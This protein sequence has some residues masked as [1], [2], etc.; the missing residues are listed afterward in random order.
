M[1]S[2]KTF[3]QGV[4]LVKINNI[5]YNHCHDADFF[6]ERPEGSGDYLLLLLK[7]DAIF[8]IDGRDIIVPKDSVFIYPKGRP[9]YYR[10]LPQHTFENDWLHFDFT[11]KD[12]ESDFIGKKIPFETPIP[13]NLNFLSYCIK[14]ISYEKNSNHP[15]REQ[16]IRSY[17]FLMFIKIAEQVEKAD[18]YR[19]GE[20][21]EMLATIRNKIYAEPYVPRG[22][23]WAAHEVRMSRSTFQHAYKKMFGV[24][25]VQDFIC[26]KISYSKM[27]LTSTN[28]TIEEVAKQS[29]Y[30]SYVHYARQFREQTGMSPSEYRKAQSEVK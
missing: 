1:H 7:T 30:R 14:S 13:M 19:S 21:Y 22:V 6:I 27:L 26:S 29:G 12:K 4:D 5:G 25:Y 15:Y 8:T 16:S 18:V 24:S 17:L 20:Q 23:N 9:Q 28:L 3:V 10:C 11:T 2:R